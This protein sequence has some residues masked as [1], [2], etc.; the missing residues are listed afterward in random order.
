MKSDLQLITEYLSQKGYDEIQAHNEAI[1][2]LKII[3]KTNFNPQ[4]EIEKHP[5]TQNMIETVKTQCLQEEMEKYPK[6]Y[7]HIR[8]FEDGTKYIQ[9][10]KN[11]DIFLISK[12]GEKSK[13]YDKN[14]IKSCIKE[15]YYIEYKEEKDTI[16]VDFDGVIHA[17]SKGWHDGTIYDPPIYNTKSTLGYLIKDYDI[18]IFSTRT[19]S[20]IID[21]NPENGQLVEMTEWLKKHEIPYTNIWL[22]TGKPKCKFI[23]DD[24]AIRFKSWGLTFNKIKDLEKDL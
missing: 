5:E 24:N 11:G 1:R 21:G 3:E 4:E 13:C 18:V 6:K 10:E 8:G 19:Y 9:I 7:V 17:Y 16:L 14:F 22:G 12:K 2:V 20:R 23:I 15:G